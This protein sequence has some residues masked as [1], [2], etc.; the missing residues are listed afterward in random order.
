MRRRGERGKLARSWISL[1]VKSMASCGYLHQP[2]LPIPYCLISL[3]MR[4]MRKGRS[5]LTPATP[6]FSMA[7]ILCPA[8]PRRNS[9][10]T[11]LAQKCSINVLMA[12][13]HLGDLARAP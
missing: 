4:D 9:I 7:G 2:L 8:Y 6:R 10:S 11:Q 13:T 1:S 5:K 3:E 12:S